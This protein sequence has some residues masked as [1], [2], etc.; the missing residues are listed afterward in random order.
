MYSFSLLSFASQFGQE[1][2][3]DI[4]SDLD[5][6]D[7]WNAA[8]GVDKPTETWDGWRT[9]TY[10]GDDDDDDPGSAMHIYPVLLHVSVFL[11]F[12]MC[13]Y[14]LLIRGNPFARPRNNLA[15]RQPVEL[16]R[17]G[18]TLPDGTLLAGNR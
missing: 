3:E 16:R 7:E 10:D 6:A 2:L 1:G 17:N 18:D 12:V 14:V 11:P 13:V 8:G 5:D 9:I 4:D 15:G